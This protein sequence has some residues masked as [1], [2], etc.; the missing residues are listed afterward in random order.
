M[1][2]SREDADI[3]RA[4]NWL[5]EHQSADGLWRGSYAAGA[6]EDAA[7]RNANTRERQLWLTLTVE[8]ILKRFYK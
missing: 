2:Y 8:R 4:L 6:E 3:R 7:S 1:G 5:F